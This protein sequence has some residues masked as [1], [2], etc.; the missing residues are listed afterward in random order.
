MEPGGEKGEIL[1]LENA[2]SQSGLMLHSIIYDECT[3]SRPTL[4]TG[5]RKGVP[6][7]SSPVTGFLLQSPVGLAEHVTQQT[8][9]K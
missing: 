9:H 1:N 3:E 5:D 4:G 6:A 7:T 2:I 8:F